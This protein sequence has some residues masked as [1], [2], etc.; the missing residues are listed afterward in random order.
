MYNFFKTSILVGFIFLFMILTL[1]NNAYSQITKSIK[2]QLTE[3]ELGKRYLKLGNTW[4]E[5][6]EKDLSKEFLDKGYGIISKIMPNIIWVYISN[7]LGIGIETKVII[8]NFYEVSKEL[9]Q[10][11]MCMVVSR[12]ELAVI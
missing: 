1:N 4:R 3:L 7:T 5:V 10:F 2:R 9:K 8:I 6:G 12:M 11:M